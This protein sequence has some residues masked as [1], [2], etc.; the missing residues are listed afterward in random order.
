MKRGWEAATAALFCVL[1]CPAIS[2]FEVVASTAPPLAEFDK[3]GTAVEGALQPE[4]LTA[5]VD[6]AN[7]GAESALADL[8]SEAETAGATEEELELLAGGLQAVAGAGAMLLA[9]GAF[10]REHLSSI[11]WAFKALENAL[12]N[13]PWSWTWYMMRMPR[14]DENVFPEFRLVADGLEGRAVGPP[15]APVVIP[16]GALKEGTRRRT[17]LSIVKKPSQALADFLKLGPSERKKGFALKGRSYRPEY[18]REQAIW[19]AYV[20]QW[21]IP[22]NHPLFFSILT[23]FRSPRTGNIYLVLPRACCDLS[24]YYRD[25]PKSMDVQHAAAEMAY[26]LSRLH[27]LGFLHRDIKPPN[28]FV[29]ETGHIQLADF[30]MLWPISLPCPQEEATHTR[31]FTAPEL[32]IDSS[33]VPFSIKTDVYA[34]GVAFARLLSHVRMY[35]DVPNQKAFVRLIVKMVQDDIEKRITL[36]EVLADVYFQGIDWEKIGRGEGP[37]PCPLAKRLMD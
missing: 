2:D 4:A 5:S 17:F 25:A 32:S 23:A 7:I 24:Q 28:Y 31:G 9:G 36:D 11:R 8:F 10:A 34:L 33:Y 13:K 6:A 29:S 1:I 37:P 12:K 3:T 14:V 27:A 21:H 15:G 26:S 16:G 19:E 30:E 20:M 18:G 22:R 35:Q